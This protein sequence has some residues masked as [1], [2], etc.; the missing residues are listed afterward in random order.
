MSPAWSSHGVVTVLA[1]TI[2]VSG[3]MIFLSLLRTTTTTTTTT[4]TFSI[5]NCDLN[6]A[7]SPPQTPRRRSCLSSKKKDRKIKKKVRFAE[8][9]CDLN[10]AESPPQTPRR[11][12]CLSSKK[13][14]RKIKKKVRFAENVKDI[15]Y[16]S[17]CGSETMD[18]NGARSS[19]VEFS[20]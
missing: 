17:N 9:N 10:H 5:K 16:V 15:E 7:E 3:T 14:D 20:C 12:S 18:F 1:T 19:L 4:N 6:H 11:R 2:A 8:N 13:K